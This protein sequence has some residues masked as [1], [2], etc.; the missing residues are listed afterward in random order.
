MF[1]G[2]SYSIMQ[3]D[4]TIYDFSRCSVPYES[5]FFKDLNNVGKKFILKLPTN[6]HAAV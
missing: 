3:R 5:V 1:A 6:L 2:V 4:S